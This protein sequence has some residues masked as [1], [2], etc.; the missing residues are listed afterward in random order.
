MRILSRPLI[1]GLVLTFLAGL[2]PEPGRLHAQDAA[3]K[4]GTP[5]ALAKDS[6]DALKRKDLAAFTGMFHPAELERFQ[7]FA[8]EVFK[9]EPS[10]AEVQAVRKLL[11][12]Y[13]T[14][15]KVAAAGGPEL[16]SAFM[17]NSLLS[18]PG[19]DELL[20]DAELQILGELPEGDSKVHVITRTFLPR[21][22]PVSCQKHEGK[23]RLLLNEE[24]IRI[25]QAFQRKRAA[26][27]KKVDPAEVAARLKL[28]AIDVI[29]HVKDGDEL[30]QVLCRVEMEQ[31]DLKFPLLACYPVRSG[32]DAWKHLA[33]A[34]ETELVKALRAKW[35]R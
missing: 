13:D 20:A 27:E 2:S 19:V 35:D 17:K 6:F 15:E 24:T 1:H 7:A 8:V 33:D 11:A 26:I 5:S 16:L 34:D 18:I 12:P 32:E 22:S 31:G 29:G 21:P 23:W 9:G 25:I 30:A 14:P 4:Q 3:P 28:G 10:D